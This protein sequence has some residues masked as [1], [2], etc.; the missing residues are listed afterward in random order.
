M[1]DPLPSASLREDAQIATPEMDN[2]SGPMLGRFAESIPGSS[3][4]EDSSAD[5]WDESMDHHEIL[6]FQDVSPYEHVLTS[7]RRA[8]TSLRTAIVNLGII[9]AREQML[10]NNHWQL[11]VSRQPIID[12]LINRLRVEL[13]QVIDAGSRANYVGRLEAEDQDN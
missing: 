13:G 12:D 3:T 5:A 10:L 9:R 6:F 8:L 4:L 11:V 2:S 7:P 1:L